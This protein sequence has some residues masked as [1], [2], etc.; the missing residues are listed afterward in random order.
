MGAMADISN[1]D[2]GLPRIWA[3]I[4]AG[5]TPASAGI[6]AWMVALR[7]G[8]NGLVVAPRRSETG[9]LV[10]G[11]A[12]RGRLGRRSLLVPLDALWEAVAATAPAV[13]PDVALD[14]SGIEAPTGADVDQALEQARI[15]GFAGRTWLMSGDEALLVE[16]ASS[17]G[18]LGPMGTL[19]ITDPRAS[20]KGDEAHAAWLRQAGIDGVLAPEEHISAGLVALMHRFGRLLVADGADYRRTARRAFGHG[21]DGVVGSD[22]EALHDGWRD[23]SE[24]PTGR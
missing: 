13:S 12:R 17:P 8:A 19:H 22:A 3:R 16:L 14:L 1:P 11:H 24:P 2:E 21:V 23:L 20:N 6:E 18:R 4:G 7:I 5:R 10:L 15:R 9:D